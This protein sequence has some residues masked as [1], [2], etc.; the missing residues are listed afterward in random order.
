MNVSL[1]SL[2]EELDQESAAALNVTLRAVF[3]SFQRFHESTAG[4]L[5]R[6][7]TLL[8]KKTLLIGCLL[9][10]LLTWAGIIPSQ[11]SWLGIKL[12]NANTSV[13]YGGL[14]LV[15]SYLFRSFWWRADLEFSNS[16][17]RRQTASLLHQLEFKS[18]I[19]ELRAINSK[20]AEQIYDDFS[21]SV[22]L[23]NEADPYRASIMGLNF[24]S[25]FFE[26]RLPQLIYAG[27]SSSCIYFMFKTISSA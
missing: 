11:I 23:D 5:L 14:S 19:D 20:L 6:E 7:D 2:S 22:F 10:F 8:K 25:R 3:L 16:R 15:L 4:S 17:L 26:L 18:A 24:R 27:A 12:T 21:E 9:A 1:S 13:I